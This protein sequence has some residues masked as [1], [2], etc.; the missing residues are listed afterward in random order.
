M[1]D[2]VEVLLSFF[3]LISPYM[4]RSTESSPSRTSCGLQGKAVDVGFVS[5]FV[6]SSVP[7]LICS[8]HFRYDYHHSSHRY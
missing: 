6:H 5:I 2:T 1:G 8:L 7:C 4:S 3:R